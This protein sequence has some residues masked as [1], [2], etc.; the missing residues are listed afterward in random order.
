[1]L[2]VLCCATVD[3]TSWT[4]YPSDVDMILGDGTPF[5]FWVDY[6]FPA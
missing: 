5:G 1:M 4:R 6:T 3:S 2:Q